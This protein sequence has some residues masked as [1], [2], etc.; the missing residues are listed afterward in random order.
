MIEVIDVW[1]KTV[2]IACEMLVG[3]V[4]CARAADAGY[5]LRFLPGDGG[6]FAR[7]TRYGIAPSA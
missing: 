2:A 1:M 5:A 4:D 3:D 7:F 6:V